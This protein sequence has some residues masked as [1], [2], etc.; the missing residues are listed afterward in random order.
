MGGASAANLGQ[1]ANCGSERKAQS[2][3]A[4]VPAMLEHG[5][6]LAGLLQG[7]GLVL[8]L[9]TKRAW[10]ELAISSLSSESSEFIYF[11]LYTARDT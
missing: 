3:L 1:D 4:S 8:L 10:H 2:Q 6:F 9:T 5:I 7:F 11:I